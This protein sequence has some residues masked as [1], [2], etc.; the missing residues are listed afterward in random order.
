VRHDWLIA[1]ALAGP[2]LLVV[3]AV[4]FAEPAKSLP[5][6]LPGHRAGSG[7]HYAKHGI[8][9]DLVGCACLVYARFRSGTECR[10]RPA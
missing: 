10:A 2:A 3:G 1:A 4:D 9:A 7:P 8:T 5:A 6:F